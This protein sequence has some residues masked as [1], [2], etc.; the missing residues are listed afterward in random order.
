MFN[1]PSAMASN[2]SKPYQ[3]AIIQSVGL[4]TPPTLITTDPAAAEILRAYY[5][6]PAE[7]LYDLNADPLETKNLAADP[8]HA[9]TLAK[10]RADLDGWMK[11]NGDEGL[12][13][14]RVIQAEREKAAKAAG[15]K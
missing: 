4:A 3:A 7:E 15:A 8:A 14:E 5:K 6:R 10:L 9:A 2:G 13:T 11:A 1:R 12:K